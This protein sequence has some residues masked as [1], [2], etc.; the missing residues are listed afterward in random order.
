VIS[1]SIG[2]FSC[3]KRKSSFKYKM[4]RTVVEGSSESST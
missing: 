4:Y 1:R 3:R 2:S